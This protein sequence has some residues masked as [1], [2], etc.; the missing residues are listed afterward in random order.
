[1]VPM[2]AQGH[3]SPG[4][5]P[6]CE[7]SVVLGIEPESSTKIA[8]FL[9]CQAISLAQDS[10]Y[11]FI[12]LFILFMFFG[13]ICSTGHLSAF[14]YLSISS[15]DCIFRKG[16]RFSSLQVYRGSDYCR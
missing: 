8:G 5:T 6:G 14:S 9:K 16:C 13:I 15:T 1:M 4:A 11:G 7:P 3:Q 2:E 12:S 10:I